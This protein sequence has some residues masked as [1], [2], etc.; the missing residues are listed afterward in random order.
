MADLIRA[1]LVGSKELK[2]RLRKMNPAE[3]HR[4][5]TPALL[6]SMLFTLRNAARE[7]IL[8]GG[9]PDAP[10]D[11]RRLTKRSGDLQRSLGPNF[12]VNLNESLQFVEGGTHLIYGAVHENSKRAFLKPALKES[13]PKFEAIFVKHWRR[14]GEVS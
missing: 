1:Q 7:Q 4:I 5:T 6:E 3:N 2:R 10:V 8:T 9:G 14:G 11:P 13:S 12:G